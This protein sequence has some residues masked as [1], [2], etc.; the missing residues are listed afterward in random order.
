M[1]DS[2]NL[3]MNSGKDVV[4]STE[5]ILTLFQSLIADLYNS[6]LERVLRHSIYTLL[7]KKKLSFSN[8][9]KFILEIEYR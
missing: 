6:K 2:V 7:V 8:L 3:F 4:T 5:L 9:R 1:E